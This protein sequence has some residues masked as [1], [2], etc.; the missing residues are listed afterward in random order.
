MTTSD[1]SAQAKVVDRF[2]V[3]DGLRTRVT[4]ERRCPSGLDDGTRVAGRAAKLSCRHGNK[5][6]WAV[7]NEI[8]GD[9]G[10]AREE[11]QHLSRYNG[12][13]VEYSGR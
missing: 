10:H 6:L 8:R 2:G 4:R 1:Y 7:K 5:R 9:H 3:P 11:N 13:S 12:K